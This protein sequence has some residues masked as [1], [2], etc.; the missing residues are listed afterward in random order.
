MDEKKGRRKLTQLGVRKIGTV[1]ILVKAKQEG[2][3]PIIQPELET[4]RN[5]GFSL[6][7]SVVDATLQ[8][9]GE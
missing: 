5:R 2:L 8:Q 6:S 3:L 1:G 9:A 4:L 7:Q